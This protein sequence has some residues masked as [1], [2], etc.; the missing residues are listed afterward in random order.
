[1]SDAASA[2]AGRSKNCIGGLREAVGADSVDNIHVRHRIFS[3]FPNKSK[4][5]EL[6]SRLR[7][8]TACTFHV[9]SIVIP[10]P[11][12]QVLFF[13]TCAHDKQE[14]CQQSS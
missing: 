11:P 8:E 9:G 14:K 12:K 5:C 7:P 3:S 13:L 6:R 4:A 2:K 10:K 1:M